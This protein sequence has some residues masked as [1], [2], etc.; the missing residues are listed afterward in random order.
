MSATANQAA[1]R[2]SSTADFLA[3]M[4]SAARCE[5]PTKQSLSNLTAEG[6][7]QF[8]LASEIKIVFAQSLFGQI[9]FIPARTGIT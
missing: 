1:E 3:A 2:I 5:L 9:L 6:V 8:I 7:K 4:R